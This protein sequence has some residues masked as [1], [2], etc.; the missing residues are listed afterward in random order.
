MKKLI[1]TFTVLSVILAVM[2]GRLKEVTVAEEFIL[3]MLAL[4]LQ[5]VGLMHYKD[6]S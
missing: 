5:Q 3:I 4:I 2:L 6:E 1:N